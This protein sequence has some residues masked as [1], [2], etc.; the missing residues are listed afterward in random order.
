MD[1]GGKRHGNAFNPWGNIP[2]YT[3]FRKLNDLKQKTSIVTVGNRSDFLGH[4][5]SPYLLSYP[6][7]NSEKTVFLCPDPLIAVGPSRIILKQEHFP[8]SLHGVE[9]N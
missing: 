3:L 5:P 8:I 7:G 4:S 6:G 9:L 1:V 2:R